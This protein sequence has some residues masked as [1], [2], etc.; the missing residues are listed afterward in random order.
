MSDLLLLDILETCGDR[1]LDQV[2]EKYV[3]TAMC[4]EGFWEQ[5]A[6]WVLNET[7]PE[8]NVKI[9]IPAHGNA[10]AALI[11]P[12]QPIYMIQKSAVT[13][14]QALLEALVEARI[15]FARIA[16]LPKKKRS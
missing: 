14:A 16:E 7:V 13:P 3:L 9:S 4:C 11:D 6:L 5:A 10:T 15:V 1:P 12:A 8:W 2:E